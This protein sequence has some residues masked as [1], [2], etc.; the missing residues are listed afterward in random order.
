MLMIFAANRQTGEGGQGRSQ[1]Q[2]LVLRHACS[3]ISAR[4]LPP[5]LLATATT[6]PLCS[7]RTS[8]PQ[9][10]RGWPDTWTVFHSISKRMTRR[11]HVATESAVFQRL[12]SGIAPRISPFKVRQLSEV[13]THDKFS[14]QC[15]DTFMLNMYLCC[16]AWLAN[17]LW[18]G[19]HQLGA[20]RAGHRRLPLTRTHL[21]SSLTRTRSHDKGSIGFRVGSSCRHELEVDRTLR[22]HLELS[23]QDCLS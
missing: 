20:L 7:S 8:T 3:R 17:L 21:S 5:G 4:P 10:S 23:P 6:L 9:P 12:H 13:H 16:R 14:G 11:R 19:Q 1:K 15:T 2:R 18:H 22:H